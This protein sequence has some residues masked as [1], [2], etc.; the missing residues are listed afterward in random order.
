[1]FRKRENLGQL[2]FAARP[3]ATDNQVLQERAEALDV[4]AKLV[5]LG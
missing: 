4:D 1:M 2:I 3:Q 5:V